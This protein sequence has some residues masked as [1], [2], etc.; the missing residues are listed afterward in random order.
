MTEKREQET[1]AIVTLDD[2][3]HDQWHAD[4]MA[5]RGLTV[6][7]RL[8]ALNGAKKLL[9]H[10]E[11]KDEI[12]ALMIDRD[13][14]ILVFS[15]PGYMDPMS[16]AHMQGYM[17]SADMAAVT[18]MRRHYC[19]A[20]GLVMM[21]N[22]K[23][24]K[25]E[26]T[27]HR[28]NPLKADKDR[29]LAVEFNNRIAGDHNKLMV[30]G[31]YGYNDAQSHRD[32]IKE[33][34]EFIWNVMK[35]FRKENPFASVS[36]LGDL[37][38]AKWTELDTDTTHHSGEAVE[39]QDDDEQWE[40]EPDAFVIDHLESFG[41]IDVLR[42]RYPE[43]NLVTRRAKHHKNRLLDRI[44]VTKE[45]N[46]DTLRT[47]IYQPAIFTHG[48][49]DTDHKLV[50][51][52][53]SVDCAGGAASRVKLW[54]KHKKQ[55][56]RWDADDMG[57]IA[58]EKKDAFNENASELAPG[59]NPSGDELNAWLR[60]A[61]EGTVMK[62]TL[63][64]FPKKARQSK[65]FQS[66]DW[67]VRASLKRMREAV[68]KIEEANGERNRQ[69]KR[70]K[71]PLKGIGKNKQGPELKG[72]HA[73]CLGK[74]KEDILVE[75]KTKV[76][77]TVEWLSRTARNQRQESIR[78]N[79]KRRTSRFQHAMK[80]KLK[81]VITS[82]MKR[83]SV[84]EEITTCNKEDGKGTATT[85]HEVAREVMKFYEN[86][87][88]SKV[89]WNKRWKTID[90]MFNLNTEGLVRPQD[91]EFVEMAYRD[92]YQK[93]GALQRESGIWDEVWADITLQTVKKTL[94]RMKSG[95]AG[96]PSELTY[97]VIKALN[98][99]N[100]EIIRAQL[101]Q[102][103]IDKGLPKELNRSLLRPLPKTD[104]GLANLALTRPIALMEVIGKLFEKILMD[105]ILS[106][107][108]EQKMLDPS[109]HGACLSGQQPLRCTTWRKRS[110]TL[111]SQDR[112]YMS[113][114]RTC[115][116]PLTLSSTGHNQ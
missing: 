58:N 45:L 42:D 110:R 18:T 2:C 7:C 25:L 34:H 37:N 61:A 102:Y 104:A 90:D 93:F 12:K 39:L 113:P 31:Y 29:V 60:K 70:A 4:S 32:K 82:I 41:L 64:E 81:C 109:Q 77:A 9:N 52:D 79:K 72:L 11:Y 23:W 38:A 112:K 47:G 24:S 10:D 87:M 33:M 71:K 68:R 67:S 86:W 89:G 43:N 62:A 74:R 78:A 105:R 80:K 28:F 1:Q 98:D 22:R 84:H 115:Q 75:L 8:A 53:L 40:R 73:W 27:V 13:I 36:L 30:I 106:V 59:P 26:R 111:R 17:T 108:V 48:G 116:R 103:L 114:L 76:D 63:Q 21:I 16:V 5:T 14:D 65:N 97:E 20:G 94:T 55:T 88:K 51:A 57:D 19:S 44:F 50:V 15:E 49:V 56:L 85:V 6:G 3:I 101:Q 35:K 99:D 83:A 92:S 95:T 66:D 107:L 91:K 54:E 96:G 69:M 46:T 100:L